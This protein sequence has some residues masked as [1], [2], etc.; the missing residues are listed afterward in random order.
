M[1]HKEEDSNKMNESFKDD[2]TRSF[3][4]IFE[5]ALEQGTVVHSTMDLSALDP[6]KTVVDGELREDKLNFHNSYVL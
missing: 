1:A 2:V 6:G 3:L 4:A 5:I